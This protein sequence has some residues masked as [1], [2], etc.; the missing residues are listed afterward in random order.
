MN[1]AIK[2]AIGGLFT[3]TSL[4]ELLTGCAEQPKNVSLAGRVIPGS[5]RYGASGAFTRDTYS[6]A[7]KT[8]TGRIVAIEV[9]PDSRGSSYDSISIRTIDSLV[10]PGYMVTVK[11]PENEAEKQILNVPTDKIKVQ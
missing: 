5:E 10:S 9:V 2:Y 1:K 4:L 6:F 7:M 3:I 8:E 11:V